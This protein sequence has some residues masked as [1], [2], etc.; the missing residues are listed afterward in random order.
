MLLSDL[1]VRCDCKQF[2]IDYE[3]IKLDNEQITVNYERVSA[4]IIW[5]EAILHSQM[6]CSFIT[7]S[8]IN[9]TT[10]VLYL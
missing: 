5:L 6:H 2:K 8:E 7:L 1:K 4:I 3:Q 9:T 10:S